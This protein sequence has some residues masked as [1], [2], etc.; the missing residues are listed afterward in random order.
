[1]SNSSTSE[2]PEKRS[3]RPQDTSVEEM[4]IQRGTHMYKTDFKAVVYFNREIV[5]SL[6]TNFK[7]STLMLESWEVLFKENSPKKNS[8]TVY[9]N[10]L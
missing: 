3:R 4:M 2:P 8:K 1:M 9:Y 7:S 5:M 10:G 6:E